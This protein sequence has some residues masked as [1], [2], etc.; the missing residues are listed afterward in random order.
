[1]VARVAGWEG[2]LDALLE[3]ARYEPYVLGE[4]D[5]FRLTCAVLEALTGVDRWPEFRGYRTKREALSAMARFGGSFEDAG[6]RFFGAPRVTVACA[7]RGDIVALRDA[8][9]AKHLC[10]CVGVD[11]AGLRE[12]G[13]EF[14]RL[15]SP[16]LICAWRVG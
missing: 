8:A 11:V 5:C 12:D 1:V 16:D 7:R 3:R 9:G 4:W 13:L 15:S 2:R 6:D 14:V 10:V